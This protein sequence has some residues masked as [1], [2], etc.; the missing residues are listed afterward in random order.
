[1]KCLCAR[2]SYADGLQAAND[3]KRASART[4]TNIV[5]DQT[6]DIDHPYLSALTIYWGQLLDHDLDLTEIPKSVPCRKRGVQH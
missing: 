6:E 3:A 5:A 2:T 4:V 1:M